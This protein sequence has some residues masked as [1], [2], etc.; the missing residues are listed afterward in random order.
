MSLVSKALGVSQ[1]LTAKPKSWLDQAASA[2][3][4]FLGGLTQGIIGAAKGAAHT[5]ASI[6]ELGDRAMSGLTGQKPVGA[7][8]TEKALGNLGIKN[9]LTPTNTAQSLGYGAEQIGEFFIPGGAAAKGVKVAEK[10]IGALKVGQIV[11]GLA[12]DVGAGEKVAKVIG[13]V[14][15]GG[16]KLGSRV[17]IDATVGGGVTAAQGGSA[18]DVVKNALIS[19]AVPILGS[20]LK[21]TKPLARGFANKIETVILKPSATDLKDGFNVQNVFKYKLGGSL[22]S[23]AEK[24]AASIEQRASEL[25]TL[26]K[27]SSERLN[28]NTLIDKAETQMSSNK[29]SNFGFNSKLKNAFNTL[30]AEVQHLSADG[31]VDLADAQQIKRSVGKIGAWQYGV[32]DPEAT[33]LEKAANALY[34][35][36]RTGIESVTP[37]RLKAIN[38]E[39]SDLIPIE[40]AIIRRIPVAERNSILSLPD[41]ISAASSLSSPQNLWLFVL[42]RLTKS[43]NVANVLDKFGN[44]KAPSGNIGTMIFGGKK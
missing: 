38:Q 43:G 12:K 28:I 32:R 23:T 29:A 30:R 36:L 10:G 8:G 44:A 37:D 34:T 2:S 41:I 17:A 9:A 35:E 20:A 39:L 15:E 21:A 31:V 13:G 27:D 7:G 42:N 11:S 18:D 1:K 40:N 24:T 25:K 14:V 26:I 16:A 22:Q 19:G 3:D 6:G 33:A 5:V 4:S